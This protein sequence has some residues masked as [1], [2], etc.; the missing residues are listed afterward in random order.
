MVG[1][2]E[3][4]VGD[5]R[6]LIVVHA[7]GF[8]RGD[9]RVILLAVLQVASADIVG[10]KLQERPGHDLVPRRQPVPV[11][12]KPGRPEGVGA[13][14]HLLID[15]HL[16]LLEPDEDQQWFGRFSFLRLLLELRLL[17]FVLLFHF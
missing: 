9:E 2:P 11:V 17:L 16:D 8:D 7:D 10:F 4:H 5:G 6:L 3:E 14:L 15:V 13:D 1:A 12:R